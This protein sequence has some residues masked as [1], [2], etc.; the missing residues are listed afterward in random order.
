MARRKISMTAWAEA[1]SAHRG[2]P[3]YG[4]YQGMS[5]GGAGA[6]LGVTR[7]YIHLL[8]KTGDLDMLELYLDEDGS[9]RTVAWL[10]THNS[11][12]RWALARMHDQADLLVSK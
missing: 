12:E 5:P 2:K 8:V 6:H 1:L 10:V 11:I 7:Q 9:Q 3:S 4:D